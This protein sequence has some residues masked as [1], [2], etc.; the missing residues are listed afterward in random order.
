MGYYDS[1]A[2]LTSLS[3][4]NPYCITVSGQWR[5]EKDV[6]PITGADRPTLQII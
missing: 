5:K 2:L 3:L 6:D 4:I 1:V